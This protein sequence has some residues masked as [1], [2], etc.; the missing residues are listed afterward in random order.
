MASALGRR[1]AAACFAVAQEQ[2]CVAE[3][4]TSLQ[5]AQQV[6]RAQPV[7]SA[8]ASPQ[9]GIRERIEIVQDLLHGL[10]VPARNLVL[11]LVTRR[12]LRL[13]DDVVGEYV[14]MAEVAS[15]VLRA[16][17]VSAVPLDAATEKRVAQVLRERFG[18]PVRL[19]LEH[20]P[21]LLGGLIIHLGD[22]VVDDSLQTHLQQLQAVLA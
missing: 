13:L 18:R 22:R 14:N 11:L 2:D 20:D 6:L 1:Y 9:M 5:L 15:G 4:G 19:R 7:R 8:L 12:R 16:T 3:L 21:S 10:A 17:V